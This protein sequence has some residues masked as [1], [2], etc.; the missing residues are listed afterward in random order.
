MEHYLADE[1]SCFYLGLL[2]LEL[3]LR[4]IQLLMG[5]MI[6]TMFLYNGKNQ[7]LNDL[8]LIC[9]MQNFGA[10]K[11]LRNL[12]QPLPFTDENPE[13]RGYKTCLG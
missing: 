11:D 6:S 2:Y 12:L 13:A 8:I 1:R 3:L 9:R 5:I 7:L 10:K 4:F